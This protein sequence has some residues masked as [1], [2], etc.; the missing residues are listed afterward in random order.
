VPISHLG[1]GQSR[2]HA[3]L[4]TQVSEDVA[5]GHKRLLLMPGLAAFS[6]KSGALTGILERIA[7]RAREAHGGRRSAEPLPLRTT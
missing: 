7:M 5:D 4:N 6:E 2:F 3:T 1:I